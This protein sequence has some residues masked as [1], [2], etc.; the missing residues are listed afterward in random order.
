MPSVAVIN[1]SYN[2]VIFDILQHRRR[3][4]VAS[5]PQIIKMKTFVAEKGLTGYKRFN[6]P[7]QRQHDF[8][9]LMLSSIRFYSKKKS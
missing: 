6:R 2:S 7:E 8:V 4:F 1:Y 3:W 5:L 9:F